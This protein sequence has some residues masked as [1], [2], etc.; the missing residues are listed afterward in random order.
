MAIRRPMYDSS[1]RICCCCCCCCFFLVAVLE[2]E[3]LVRQ[4]VVM[5]DDEEYCFAIDSLSVLC[6]PKV[7][8]R[9]ATYQLARRPVKAA[10]RLM[11]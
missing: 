10:T 1:L 2:G 11:Y 9:K 7:Q 8:E 5:V 4:F 6:V 3:A